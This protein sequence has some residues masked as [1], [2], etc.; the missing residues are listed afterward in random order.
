MTSLSLRVP[1]ELA[2][3]LDELVATGRYRSRSAA[4][5]AAIDRM[6]EAE[7]KRDVDRAI[8]AGYER[9]PAEPPDAFEL[10][11]AARSVRQEPW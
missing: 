6:L 5:E 9:V 7:R 10:S 1:A 11:L 3:Q 8:I 2:K 4:I